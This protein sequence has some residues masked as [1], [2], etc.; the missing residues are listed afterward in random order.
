MPE[1][2]AIVPRGPAALDLALI[3]PT[4]SG[5]A[6]NPVDQRIRRALAGKTVSLYL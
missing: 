2:P 6:D 3:P 4:Q 5:F 1:L